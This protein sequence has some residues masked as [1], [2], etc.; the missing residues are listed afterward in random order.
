MTWRQA[1]GGSSF[2]VRL[3]LDKNCKQLKTLH[4]PLTAQAGLAG[5]PQGRWWG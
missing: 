5:L 4:I 2:L 3:S 1:G